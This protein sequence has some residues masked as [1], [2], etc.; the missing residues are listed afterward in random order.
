MQIEFLLLQF[1]T[2]IGWWMQTDYFKVRS[3]L[4]NMKE[5]CWYVYKIPGKKTLV[6]YACIIKK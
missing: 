6:V 5:N 2:R 4:Y 1:Y 3:V